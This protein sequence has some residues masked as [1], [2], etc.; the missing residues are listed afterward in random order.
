MLE[1]MKI[2]SKDII[3]RLPCIKQCLNF[4]HG[5]FEVSLKKAEIWVR[6]GPQYLYHELTDC[7][8]WG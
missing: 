8:P 6:L 5:E 2:C 4:V 7:G 1:K 3:Y